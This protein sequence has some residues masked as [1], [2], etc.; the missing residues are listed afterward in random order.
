MYVKRNGEGLKYLAIFLISLFTLLQAQTLKKIDVQLQWKNQFEFAGF[1]VAIEK[2]FYSDVGLDVRTKEWNHG[3]D[4]VDELIKQKA[5][6]GVVRPTSL[7]D[8]AKGKSL[9]YLA[10]FYQSSPLILL[11]DTSSNITDISDLKNKKVMITQDQMSDSSITSMLFS[12]G[13]K[14][15]DIKVIKHSFDVNDLLNKKVDLMASYISNE[16]YVLQKLGGSPI[17][18]RP[19]DYGFDFYNDILATSKEYLNKNKEEVKKFKEATLKGYE[20]AFSNID[21]TVEIILKKY[22]T[23][24][25]SKDVLTYEAQELKKLAYQ[26]NHEFAEITPTKLERMFDVYKL[27]GHVKNNLNLNEFIYNHTSLETYL[28]QDEKKYIKDKKY[29]RVCID[30]N[31]MPIESFDKNGD[32]IGMSADYLSLF[33]SSTGASFKVIKTDSWSESLEFIKQKKCD[34]LSL[35][36]QTNARKEFMSFTTAYM[37]IPLVVSTKIEVPFINGLK[38]LSGKK[39]GIT[40]GD[41]YVEIIRKRFSDIEVVE[42]KDIDLGLKMLSDSELFAFIGPLTSVGFRFQ[43]QYLGDLKI[44]GKIEDNLKLSVAV[45]ID[46]PFLHSILQKAVNSITPDQRRDILNKWVSVKYEKGIDYTM[47]YKALV[48]FFVILFIILYFYYKQRSL[49]KKLE[50]AYEKMQQIA[51]TDKLTNLYNRH[52][53]DTMLKVEQ[54]RAK[55]YGVIFGVIILDIDHFKLVNDKYGHHSGDLILKEFAKILKTNSR[56][57]DIVGRWGGEEFLIIV[58]HTTE[59]SI[60]SFAKILQEKVSLHRFS[61]VSKI[62]ASLGISLYRDGE[63]FEE[64]ISRA[65]QALYISKENGR[66]RYTFL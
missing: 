22:N 27:L 20:Y 11:A 2:G 62:T 43:N 17:I 7:I 53:M 60:I 59:N 36:M 35:A 31:M 37:E 4:I 42:V 33:A 54:Q 46:E 57:T 25:K 64:T 3:I 40:K 65:D 32:H 61:D 38:D 58:P 51:I 5:N 15:E 52:K 45:R 28:T 24:N 8:M 18:F 49:H 10:A 48:F 1:Y 6:Y 29:I 44:A 26:K 66:D 23:Q 21:E 30:P 50:R 13:L 14:L 39:V 19:K 41:A 9:V 12:Q 47:L 34:M 63:S 56:E 16:P 55:R